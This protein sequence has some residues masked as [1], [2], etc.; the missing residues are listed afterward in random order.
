MFVKVREMK[1]ISAKKYAMISLSAAVLAASPAVMDGIL[2]W[3]GASVA[4][5]APFEGQY[6]AGAQLNRARE[7]M[8]RQL[9]EQRMEED[10]QKK[11]AQVKPMCSSSRKKAWQ[12]WNSTFPGSMWILRKC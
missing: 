7:Y 10:L 6:D 12:R 1:G 3:T 2:P 5:A 11:K 9:T 4:W 8:D